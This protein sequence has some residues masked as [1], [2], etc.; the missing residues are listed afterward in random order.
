VDTSDAGVVVNGVNGTTV[1]GNTI[2]VT[3]PT[4]ADYGARYGVVFT[5][6]AGLSFTLDNFTVDMK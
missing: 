1:V 5:P 2:T 4:S 3:A 6:E